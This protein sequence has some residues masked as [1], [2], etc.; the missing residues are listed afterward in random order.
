LRRGGRHP[1][2]E[3]GI[4]ADKSSSGQKDKDSLARGRALV[5]THYRVGRIASDG[6]MSSAGLKVLLIDDSAVVHRIVKRL[7]KRDSRV[8]HFFAAANAADGYSLFKISRP[9]AVVLDLN[10]PDLHGLE[11]LKRIKGSSPRCVVIILTNCDLPEMREECLRHGADSFLIKESDL[12]GVVSAIAGL[13]RPA[14]GRKRA[15]A[16]NGANHG[17]SGEFR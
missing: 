11:I 16:S 1:N 13:C 15:R 9:D 3:T 10:L 12:L 17:N 8:Q 6:N 2:A 7:L 4:N 14:R 5:R